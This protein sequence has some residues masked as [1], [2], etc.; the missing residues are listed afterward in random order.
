[1]DACVLRADFAP[2]AV[3]PAVSITRMNSF[4]ICNL[5]SAGTGSLENQSMMTYTQVL[6]LVLSPFEM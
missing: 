1:M 6:L 5:T 3:V 4:H 2:E